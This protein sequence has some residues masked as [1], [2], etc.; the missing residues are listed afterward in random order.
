M[1]Q[2]T[3]KLLG[4][5]LWSATLSWLPTP[6][7][8]A[9]PGSFGDLGK[10]PKLGEIRGLTSFSESHLAVW[11]SNVRKDRTPS[12]ETFLV[13]FEL[14]DGEPAEVFRIVSSPEDVWQR[15]I[16]LDTSTSPD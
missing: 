4:V 6:S 7:A 12:Y 2:V 13:I 11:Y 14:R 15:L 9:Q 16:P 5:V 1:K 10:I 3:I 8:F